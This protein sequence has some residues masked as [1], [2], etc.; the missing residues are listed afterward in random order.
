MSGNE[1]HVVSRTIKEFEDLLSENTF[2]RI[3]NS[4]I[5]NKDYL[6][7]YERGE[8]GQ[9]IMSNGIRL[10]VSKRKKADFLKAIGY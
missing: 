10:D 6:E 8:G 3:H 5:I 2:I 1:K 7:K 4:Y 9:V